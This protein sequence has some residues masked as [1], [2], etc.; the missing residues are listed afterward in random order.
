MKIVFSC[1][2]FTLALGSSA[3]ADIHQEQTTVLGLGNDI[4]LLQ[5]DQAADAIQNLAVYNE[6][7]A[8]SGASQSFTGNLTETG[9]ASSGG[10]DIGLQQSVA[11]AGLQTQDLSGFWGLQMQ[12]PSLGGA[13]AGLDA[14]TAILSL[15]GGSTNGVS[16][17]FSMGQGAMPAAA[18]SLL[19]IR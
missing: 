15:Q 9:H 7:Q 12:M 14:T 1:L 2:V 17:P 13:F 11:G 3:L 19:A 8:A 16:L 6:Q 10:A 5:G 4:L 18:L